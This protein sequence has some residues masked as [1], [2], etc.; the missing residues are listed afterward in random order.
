MPYVLITLKPDGTEEKKV[1]SKRPPLSDM[2]AAVGGLIEQIPW[3]TTYK[4]EKCIA[5]C[6]E[7]GIGLELPENY[8]VSLGPWLNPIYGNVIFE[9]KRR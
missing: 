6:N 5:Y 7:D 1:Y 2:Q 4:G 9:I 8:H 3:I